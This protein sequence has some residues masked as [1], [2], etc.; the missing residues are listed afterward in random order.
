M[1]D[2]KNQIPPIY[3]IRSMNPNGTMDALSYGK[4][5]ISYTGAV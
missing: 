1:K 4:A 2:R 3:A 5:G